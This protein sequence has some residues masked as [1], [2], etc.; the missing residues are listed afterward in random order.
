M[1]RLLEERLAQLGETGLCIAF[2]GGVDSALLLGIAAQ[3]P[4]RVHAVTFATRLHPPGDIRSAVLLAEQVKVRHTVLDIDELED[5]RILS[6]PPERCYLCKRLLFSRL[7]AYAAQ[8][9]LGAVVDGTN[10]DDLNEYRPGLRALRELSIHSPL[11]E[12]HIG[13]G[14]VRRMARELGLSVSEKPSSPCLATRLPYGETITAEALERIA[15]GESRL[16]AAGFAQCRLRLHGEIA[17]IE[18]LPEDFPAFLKRKEA[19]VKALKELGF[20]YITL[21][22]EGFRSGSMDIHLIEKEKKTNGNETAARAG[23]RRADHRGT[24]RRDTEKTA[25]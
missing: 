3:L 15:A 9:G 5:E 24:S 22:M 23:E 7:R 14:Q 4:V 19:L 20:A 10:A 17:R 12:L 18:I 16:K 25:L 13:K 21:D 1:R 8:Q 2:S 11:A 6:N